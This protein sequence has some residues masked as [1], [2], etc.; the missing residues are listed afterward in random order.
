MHL[1]VLDNPVFFLLILMRMSGAILLNP[2]LGRKNV[3]NM[4]KIAL[5]LTISEV[6]ASVIPDNVGEIA[7]VLVFILKAVS[8]FT[9]GFS[10][11]LI[12]NIFLSS[13]DVACDVIDMQIGISLVKS[14]DPGNNTT[15]PLTGKIYSLFILTIFFITNCH[16][17]VYKLLHDSYTL[18][19]CGAYVDLKNASLAIVQILQSAFTLALKFAFPIIAVEFLTEIG[20]GVLHRAV[21]SINL[22]T[23]GLQMKIIAGVLLLALLAPAFGTFSDNLIGEMFK[24]INSVLKTLEV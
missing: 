23:V 4:V 14:Y 18:I 10:I 5:T 6:L 17:T 20:M 12:M 21:P 2:I 24:N 3:P 22:F 1:S 16:I 8:E 7:S 19:P 13:I 11:S 15:S 9:I